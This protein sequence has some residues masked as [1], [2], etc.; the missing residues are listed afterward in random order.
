MSKRAQPLAMSDDQRTT[1]EAWV[2]AKTTPQRT[3]LRARI[4]LLAAEGLSNVAIAREVK[5]SRPTVIQ[6]RRR[7]EVAGPEG[8]CVDAPHG[9]GPRVL[10]A[11]KVKG[12]VETTLHKKPGDATHWSVRTMAKAQGV[13]KS[14]VQRIW[15]AHGLQPHRMKTFK[16]SKDK[17]FVEKLTDVVGVYLNPPDKALVLCVDEKTQ[18]QALDRTQ[19]GLPMKKGRCGT[20]THDYKRNGT[21]CLFAALNILEGTVIGSCFPRH[22]NV[23][24]LK[25]LR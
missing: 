15:D 10:P 9:R 20:M 3:V 6:W 11:D 5:V 2:R 8:I 14:T 1:M 25:F 17:R 16:L 24:F 7:F 22:R 18:V 12:I 19:P 13:G 4:C 21:T 23:E